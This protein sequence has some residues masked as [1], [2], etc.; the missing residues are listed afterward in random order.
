MV[1]A[2]IHEETPGI[3]A[4]AIGSFKTNT[5][6]HFQTIRCNSDLLNLI[7]C[8]ICFTKVKDNVVSNSV[9]WQFNF[10][11]DLTKEMYNEEHLA[12]LSQQ[13][14]INFSAH[15]SHGIKYQEFAELLIDSGLLL[16]ESVNW[17]SFHAGYDLGFLISLLMN[18]GLPVDEPEF[19]WWCHK[20][21]PNF[22]DLK[23]VGNQIL[24]GDE[25]LNKPSIEYLAEELHLLPISPVIR[26]LFGSNINNNNQLTSTL[27]AYLSMECFKEILRRANFDLNTLAKFKGHIWGLGSF[28]ADREE[29]GDAAT[30]PMTPR[31][32]KSGIVNLS[33]A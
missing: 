10:A 31:N 8:S 24:S 23:Y 13:S 20:F 25:K 29:N 5:D 28:I 16:D 32:T 21:F 9:I 30:G 14:S 19:Y 18:Q 3:V 6:Y 11:Y 17:V 4:R 27:H 26:Q 22:Y 1:F 7:Q 2:A 15:S 33:R 12:M